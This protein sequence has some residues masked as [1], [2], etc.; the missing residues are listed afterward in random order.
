MV[1]KSPVLEKSEVSSLLC[2]TYSNYS[3]DSKYFISDLLSGRV[4]LKGI[5]SDSS[6][7]VNADISSLP[8]GLYLLTIID[9]P[10]KHEARFNKIS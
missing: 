8:N 3:A 5:L 10:D 6:K 1:K 9:G 7:S 2:F 4:F